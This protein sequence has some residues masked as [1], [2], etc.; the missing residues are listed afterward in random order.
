[1]VK[2]PP[3][4]WFVAEKAEITHYLFAVSPIHNISCKM[5]DIGFSSLKYGGT[6]FIKD[7]GNYVFVEKTWRECAKKYLKIVIENPKTLFKL[8]REIIK[9]ADALFEF[10]K[11]L[12]KK[13]FTNYS[14]QRLAEY[15]EKF[16][17]LH[18]EAHRR[19]APMWVME[20]SGEVFSKYIINYLDKEIKKQNLNLIPEV[21]FANL[22][23]PLTKNFTTK[24]R[25]EFLRIALELKSIKN[26]TD[27]IIK[28]KLKE[29]VKTYCWLPYGVSGP[30]WD[31]EY[32]V[33]A[34]NN[35]LKKKSDE[36]SK[37]I[38]E[39]KSQP[40][41]IKQAKENIYSRLKVDKLHKDLIK[42]AEETI[43][44]KAY[45]KEVLFFG[46]YAAEELFK[47]IAGRLGIN[48]KLLRHMLPWEIKPALSG[49][50]V[51]KKELE[52]RWE[53]SF[54]Y[55]DHCRPYLFISD[56]AK[57]FVDRLNL[58]REEEGQ[59]T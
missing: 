51:N 17:Y 54:Y 16:E 46:Y 28:E 58:K 37:E 3:Q 18:N 42:L 26:L 40:L 7:G 14:N 21:V 35:V 59:L 8:H 32:F 34:M 56:E 20:T 45:S 49:K 50:K 52:R 2:S 48:L 10:G 9:F 36:I 53:Y 1:M 13:D 11:K 41:K 4:N 19:R 44:T 23:T 12:L 55:V 43:Q 57:N 27:K 31:M 5:E 24:E 38:K 25:E 6:E 15:Y 30:V 29:H 47:E 39:I 33:M 22:S